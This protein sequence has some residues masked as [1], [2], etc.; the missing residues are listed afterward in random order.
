MTDDVWTQV[1]DLDELISLLDYFKVDVHA[2]STRASVPLSL[3]GL[4]ASAPL[5]VRAQR[6]RQ[7]RGGSV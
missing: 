4:R 5:L 2:P 1:T 3:A 7:D 6:Q